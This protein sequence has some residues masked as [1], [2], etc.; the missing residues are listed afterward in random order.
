MKITKTEA[1]NIMRMFESIDSDNGYIAFKA[2]EQ[3]DFENDNL[4]YLIYFYKYGKY[5]KTEWETNCKPLYMILEKYI[6]MNEPLTYAKGLS[7]MI[8]NECDKDVIELFLERHVKDLATMLSTMGYPLD[9]M[10][11]TLKLKDE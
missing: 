5:D 8:K 9:K 10:E 7:V 6:N 2:L 4:G 3:Y 1:D 11:F